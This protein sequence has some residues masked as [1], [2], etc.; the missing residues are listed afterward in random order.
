VIRMSDYTFSIVSQDKRHEGDEF[1]IFHV[2]G[3]EVIGVEEK[4]P[5]EL[6]FRNNTSGRVQVR[7]SVDGTDVLSGQPASTKPTG[8]MFLVSPGET[9]KLKAWPESLQG[10]ARFVFTTKE[11][12]V[13]V[14][15]H[16]NTAGI[17]L[18]AAAVFADYDDYR[19]LSMQSPRI[20]SRFQ[21]NSNSPLRG[22]GLRRSRLI[23]ADSRSLGTTK[24]GG[25]SGSS[26]TKAY[27]QGGG[28]PADFDVVLSA[29]SLD[30]AP[31]PASINNIAEASNMAVGAGE[32]TDQQLV[33]AAG[34]RRPVLDEVLQVRYLPWDKLQK[35]VDRRV[36]EATAFPGDD[37]GID[38]SNVP[39][40]KSTGRKNVEIHRFL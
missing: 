22:G 25:P 19:Y 27:Y 10:G 21:S 39:R 26:G 8:Q 33:K 14:N 20:L 30:F 12:S 4:E 31:G 5:F 16:G 35:L 38:L 24:G 36:V 40:T 23:G 2:D 32:Y 15:T 13:A 37:K 34:L 6:R 29:Q 7:L 3:E 28:D 9:M 17:G 11:R 1:R 18:I